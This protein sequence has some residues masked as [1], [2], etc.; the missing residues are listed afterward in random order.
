MGA[1]DLADVETGI[2]RAPARVDMAP[3]RRCL[4]SSRSISIGIARTVA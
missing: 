3:L 2:E 1:V 4:M